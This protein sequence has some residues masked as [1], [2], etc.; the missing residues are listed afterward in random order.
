LTLSYLA[1]QSGFSPSALPNT[2]LL[3][4]LAIVILADGMDIADDGKKAAVLRKL[5]QIAQ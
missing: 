3:I 1:P 5:V 2:F 4:Y